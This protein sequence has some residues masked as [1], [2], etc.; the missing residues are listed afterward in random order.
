[1]NNDENNFHIFCTA[2]HSQ[3]LVPLVVSEMRKSCQKFNSFSLHMEAF[4]IKEGHIFLKYHFSNRK[5]K[6]FVKE[7]FIY[8]KE[9]VTKKWY[10]RAK[11]AEY[12]VSCSWPK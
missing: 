7:L 8:K 2:F 11:P 3:D 9:A 6:T 4:C 5:N 12:F 1:M 10:R